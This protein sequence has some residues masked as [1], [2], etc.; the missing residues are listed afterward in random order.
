MREDPAKESF[1][2]ETS[3]NPVSKKAKLSSSKDGV[4]ILAAVGATQ[5]PLVIMPV[6]VSAENNTDS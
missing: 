3:L 5:E 1:N 2:P 6:A 4:S